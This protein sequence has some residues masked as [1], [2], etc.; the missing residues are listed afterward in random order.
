MTKGNKGSEKD[1]VATV[2]T[3]MQAMTQAGKF[4]GSV[5][6]AQKGKIL[7]SAGYDLA[8]REHRVPNTSQTKFRIGS[9]TKQFTA[10]AI[11]ILAEQ[12][13]LSVHDPV[14]QHLPYSPESWKEITIHHLLNHTAGLV[15]LT[16]F[17]GCL[18][19]TARLPLTVREVIELFRKKPVEFRPGSQYRYSNSGYIL[20]GDIIERASGVSYEAFLR[21]QIFDPL[22]MADSGYDRFETV[23]PHRAS[24]YTRKGGEWVVTAYV[25]MGFPYAAGA[26]YSTVEDL[27]RW[28]QALFAERLI[29][30]DSHARMTMITPL[31]AP[32]GYGLVIGREHNRR[33]V[34]HA[35]GINGF[36]ANFIRFPDETACVIALCNSEVAAFTEVT[37]ALGAILF[38]E[39]Y[40]IPEVTT[41]AKLPEAL[42]A[43]YVGAYELMPGVTLSVES[44]DGC[45]QVTSNAARNRF[46]PKSETVFYREDNKDTLTFHTVRKGG[47]SHLTLRQADVEVEAKKV[48]VASLKS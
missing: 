5:L 27:Y 16:D 39:K 43:A 10:M 26:L 12:G 48:S 4:S 25:D 2:E 45:L 31:L 13:K 29:T 7:H 28:D 21:E 8:N 19:T 3:Y 14:L 15:N 35:G 24:G 42:L 41:P 20:L 30:K 33:T 9:I 47:V 34:G 22:Q 18:E 1:I 36:R 6:L 46:L 44:Q 38:E 37:K 11:M 17:P 40:D 23:L 32:Y